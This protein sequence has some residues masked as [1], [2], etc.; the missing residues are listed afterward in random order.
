MNPL[1]SQFIAPA[2]FL[3][4]LLGL[5]I[6]YELLKVCFEVFTY[7]KPSKLYLL[8]VS[9]VSMTLT[10][11][12]NVLLA[13]IFTA[14]AVAVKGINLKDTFIITAT[15]EF[16]FILGFFTLYFIFTTI[17]TIIGIEGLKLNLD[18]DELL[19]YA[20]SKLTLKLIREPL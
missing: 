14:F 3:V 16:G 13:I 6:Y 1:E 7:K 15:T 12:V 4:M 5:L 2:D 17:G 8:L 20:M 9:A 18:W 10:L 11:F 19:H